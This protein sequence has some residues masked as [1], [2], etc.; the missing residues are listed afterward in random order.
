MKQLQAVPHAVPQTKPTPQ[1]P[2]IGAYNFSSKH[3]SS[4][5]MAL[6]NL[7][8]KFV[9]SVKCKPAGQL[10]EELR[11]FTRN[12]RLRAQFGDGKQATGNMDFYVA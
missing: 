12:V 10:D 4:D 3:F 9:T 7:G 1:L 2:V 6:L 8:L 5:T 11:V